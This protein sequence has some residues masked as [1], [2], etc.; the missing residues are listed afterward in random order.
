MWKAQEKC[1]RCNFLFTL[2][3]FIKDKNIKNTSESLCLTAFK[4]E[5]YHF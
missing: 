3:N 2:N 5:G 1:Y 4:L